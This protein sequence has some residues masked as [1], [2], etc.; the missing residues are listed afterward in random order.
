MLLPR[1]LPFVTRLLLA[2]C[3]LAS[4]ATFAAHAAVE[5]FAAASSDDVSDAMPCAD[6]DAASRNADHDAAPACDC[7]PQPHCDGAA[8]VGVG[9]LP[10]MPRWLGAFV[11]DAQ[12]LTT[13]IRIFAS[14]PLDRS[15]R[16]P[17]A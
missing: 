11:P 15:L 10:S 13:Q 1:L 17:I 5:D 2:L 9:C 3:L 14:A 6:H 12:P 16:P 7:C 8:C 4:S